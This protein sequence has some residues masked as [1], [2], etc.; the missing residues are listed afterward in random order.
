[1]RETHGAQSCSSAWRNSPM[2]PTSAATAS[3]SQ[4]VR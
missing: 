2:A 4:S 1:L 3:R